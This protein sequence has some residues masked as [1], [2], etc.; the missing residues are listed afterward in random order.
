MSWDVSIHKFSRIFASIEEM[1]EDEKPLPL[2][3]RALVHEKVLVVFPETD[4]SDPAWGMWRSPEGSVEFNVGNDP[5]ESMMLHVRAE[6][7]VVAKIVQLCVDNGWQGLD[8][9]TGDFIE[10]AGDPTRGLEAW[11]AYRDHVRDEER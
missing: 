11:T 7:S 4:W 5:V 9:S 2:G 10:Q 1:P 3:A 6:P 8:C